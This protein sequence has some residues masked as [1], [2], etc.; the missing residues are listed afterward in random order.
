MKSA[1]SLTT[2]LQTHEFSAQLQ[3]GFH[4][5]E[6]APNQVVIDGLEIHPQ[7][8]TK[9]AISF[10]LKQMKTPAT[11]WKNAVASLYVCDDANT[12]CET[13]TVP[14]AAAL[15]KAA[16]K[17]EDHPE[18]TQILKKAK[19]QNKMVLLDFSARW[20]PGCIRY[21]KEVFPQKEFQNITR[22]F[23]LLKVDVDLYQNFALAK[24]FHLQGIPTLV[25][26]DH[27]GK[28][29]H[30]NLDFKPLP[31]LK[32]FLDQ[33]RHQ[34]IPAQDKWNIETEAA[35]KKFEQSPAEKA[36]YIDVLKQAIAYEPEG[37][38]ALAWRTQ[39]ISLLDGKS[40][41]SQKIAKEGLAAVQLL[42]KDEQKRKAAFQTESP[43]EFVGFEKMLVA[44][45]GV[46]LLEEAKAE[47][48]VIDQMWNQAVE[49]SQAYHIT[50]EQNGPALRYLIFLSA[51]KKYDQAEKWVNQLIQKS[52]DNWDL[53]RRK[54]KILMGLNKNTEAIQVGEKILDRTEG[55]NQF[56]VAESL[57]KAYLAA[58]KNAEAKT[59]LQV[60]LKRSELQAEQLQGVKANYEKLLA[61]ATQ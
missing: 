41:E 57:A 46:D 5:N 39:L 52:P 59:L 51:A 44:Q 47:Q 38:R 22:D 28:E 40:D 26:L 9:S 37:I 20:C 23:L 61:Q 48:A 55:R 7:Q 58:Q 25:V 36:N 35:Q 24:R 13:H 27:D 2:N 18:L 17:E 1:G 6:K 19:A 60:Y 4:F 30:R 8:I 12:F 50:P 31:K 15:S 54:M 16:L 10:S 49:V 32:I 33:A 29:I 14:L 56:W 34:K 11:S 43:G 45:L 42:L 53:H 21:E 3:P